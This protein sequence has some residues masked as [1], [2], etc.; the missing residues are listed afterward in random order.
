VKSIAA[1]IVLIT[2][3]ILQGCTTDISEKKEK[4]PADLIP[5]DEMVDVIADMHLYDAVIKEEQKK[6][7][8]VQ[9]SKVY[10]YRTVMEKYHITREQ[11]ESS[12]KYYQQ[13]LD[14]YDKIYD[15][16]IEKLSKMKA[17]AAAENK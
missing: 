10:L 11:F 1:Y 14:E 15:D 3:F 16:V 2:F 17:E 5:R 7:R 9:K 8:N 4:P 13:D 12:L 6:H